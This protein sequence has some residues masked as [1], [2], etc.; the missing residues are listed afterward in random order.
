[1]PDLDINTPE[2]QRRWDAIGREIMA[3]FDR[4]KINA[5]V[6]TGI[7]L[8]CAAR[9]YGRDV[10]TREGRYKVARAGA[11]VLERMSEHYA[12]GGK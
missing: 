6:A 9:I 11:E 3:I 10:P 4:E 1:M 5:D 12:R 8:D 7:L 2:G